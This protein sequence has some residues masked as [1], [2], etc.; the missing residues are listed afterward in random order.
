MAQG[1]ADYVF[2]LGGSMIVI[3]VASAGIPL[4]G[5][6]VRNLRVQGALGL[7][8]LGTQFWQMFNDHPFLGSQLPG[9][10]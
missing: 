9:V 7:L 8:L 2:A 5:Y 10:P 1:R 3:T 6:F 4:V